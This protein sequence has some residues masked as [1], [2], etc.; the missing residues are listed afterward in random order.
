M[1]IM[2][3]RIN[4]AALAALCLLFSVSANGQVP[5]PTPTADQKWS[6]FVEGAATLKPGAQ[7]GGVNLSAARGRWWGWAQFEPG[8]M[9]AY[10][11]PRFSLGPVEVGVAAGVKNTPGHWQTG[12][13]DFYAKGKFTQLNL[14]ERGAKGE[15]W[16]R[17]ESVIEVTKRFSVGAFG[18]RNAGW[19][20]RFGLRFRHSELWGAVLEQRSHEQPNH[21]TVLLGLRRSF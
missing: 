15:W 3:L 21:P 10:A 6:G 1:N 16:F 14:W 13:Y 20:V 4:F 7:F 9:E 5:I 12:A 18:Q 11:G 17:N 8:F 19:G 2:R